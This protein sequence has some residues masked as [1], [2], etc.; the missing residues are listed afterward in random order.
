MS[1]EV[2]LEAG[3]T[4]EEVADVERALH[5]ARLDA[6]VT[7][8]LLRR[9]AGLYPWVVWIFV[10]AASLFFAGLIG[11]AGSDAYKA[12]KAL[13]LKLYK[14]RERSQAPKGVV[15]LR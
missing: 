13:V 9:G 3:A 4:K 14:A 5:E 6:N 10:P 8:D 1:I 15:Q 11:E 12:L 7:A 2:L